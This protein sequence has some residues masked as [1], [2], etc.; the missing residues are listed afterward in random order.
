M[1]G[2]AFLAHE[3][4]GA[5]GEVEVGVTAASI[6]DATGKPPISPARNLETGLEVF[7]NEKISTDDS[8]RAQLLFRDGTSL[9]VG[10]GSEMTID[11]YVFDPDSGSGEMVVN[12]SKGV[13]R[14][15]G[16][17]ISKNTPVVFNTPTATVAVRGGI[18]VVKEATNGLTASFIFGTGME[19][20]PHNGG[21][22]T[23]TSLPGY[24]VIVNLDQTVTKERINQEALTRTLKALEKQAEEAPPA[25]ADEPSSGS[26]QQTA[27]VPAKEIAAEPESSSTGGADTATQPQPGE[28]SID[29][30]GT[31]IASR[32]TVLASTVAEYAPPITGPT[33]GSQTSMVSPVTQIAELTTAADDTK[34][35]DASSAS[36]A[37][38]TTYC[39]YGHCETS[40]TYCSHDGCVTAP[41]SATYCSHDECEE[42]TAT[43][44]YC[45]HDECEAETAAETAAAVAAATAAAAATYCSHE[46]CVVA[47]D[48]SAPTYDYMIVSRSDLTG[49]SVALGKFNS[50]DRYG[51]SSSVA[52]S[53]AETALT[54][55]QI[56]LCRECRFLNWNRR[57]TLMTTAT[58]ST[59]EIQHWVSGVTSTASEISAAAGKTASYAGG[60]VGAV[61]TDGLIREATGGF[62]ARVRFGVSQYQVQNFNASF[63][64]R[65]YSG[66][67]GLTANDTVFGVAAHSGSQTMNA[68]GY[69]FGSPARGSAPPE[70]G[71]HFEISGK[72]YR[73]GGVFAGAQ[74]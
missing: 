9:T 25:R 63:D 19:V 61:A 57:T 69:F 35:T 66:S 56:R 6:T 28:Q 17:K 60:L 12:I 54:G 49:L 24:H 43:A 58:T 42:G 64:G 55:S 72:D 3:A 15:V 45:S 27:S 34:N 32:T 8:G 13:F 46:E 2:L 65:R 41:E 73:A 1:F 44:T 37:H 20:I 62:D 11:E 70:M 22:A 31:D 10:A 39:P 14:L 47:R 18:A 67:S 38:S 33:G 7:F 59:A 21:P 36:I 30:G 53:G 29:G 4:T 74:R 23:R 5:T 68:N 26:G 51:L 48:K 40:V 16:G 50:G 71:G 52:Q